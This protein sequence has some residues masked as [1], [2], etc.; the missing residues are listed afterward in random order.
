MT[1]THAKSPRMF[2][3]QRGIYYEVSLRT[4]ATIRARWNP[5]ALCAHWLDADN[6]RHRAAGSVYRPIIPRYHFAQGAGHD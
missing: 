3:P 2:T 6:Q 1:T 4:G 5:N